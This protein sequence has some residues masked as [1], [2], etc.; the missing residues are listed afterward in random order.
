MEP[1]REP[2]KES[3]AAAPAA[4]PMAAR[5]PGEESSTNARPGASGQKQE[6]QDLLQQAK[7]AGSEIM[8]QVQQSAGSQITRQK[9]SAA[10]DLSKVVNAVRQFGQNLSADDSGPIARYAAEY[11]D[12]AAESLERFSKYIREQDPKQLLGDVQEFG[13][14]RPALLLGGMFL[15]GFA[16]ARLIKSSMDS[17]SY[18]S[19]S[20]PNTGGRPNV[21]KPN[22]PAVKPSQTPNAS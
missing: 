4:K 20:R 10:T 19:T 1:R 14:R 6:E 7:N 16:G 2:T 8:S 3:K 11:G 12:K 5:K 21:H 13:R 15:L 9:D 17:G 18:G 22:V